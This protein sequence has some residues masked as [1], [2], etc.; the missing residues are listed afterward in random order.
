[1]DF[2]G[3]RQYK[4]EFKEEAN[5]ELIAQALTD[6]FE[7]AAPQVKR[8][9]NKQTALITTKYRVTEVTDEAN[10]MVDST[11]RAGLLE[12]GDYDIIEQK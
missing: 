10:N 11:L 2:Q 6:N 4:V 3:G 9:D 1:M 8:V 5:P 12:I 7:G